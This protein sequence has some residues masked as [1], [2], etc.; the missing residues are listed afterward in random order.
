MIRHASIRAARRRG[1]VWVCIVNAFSRVWINREKSLAGCQLKR[2]KLSFPFSCLRLR[3]WPRETGSAV[4]SHA[5]LLILHAQAESSAY[6]RDSSRFPRRPTYTIFH[7]PYSIYH[8][9]GRSTNGGGDLWQERLSTSMCI[10]F[11]D[12]I[13]AYELRRPNLPLRSTRP[14]RRTTEYDIGH[15]SIL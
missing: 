15:S 14:F 9:P 10:C 12:L 4:P 8:I 13:K 1:V 6:S 5:S 2:V 3:I 11:I 7:I